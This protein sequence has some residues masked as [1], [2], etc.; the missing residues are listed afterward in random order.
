MNRFIAYIN[1][2]RPEAIE[3]AIGLLGWLEELGE[4]LPLRP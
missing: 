2:R 3:H 4:Y 1:T